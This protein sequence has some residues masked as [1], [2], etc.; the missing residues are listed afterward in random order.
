VSEADADPERWPTV[1]VET[2]VVSYLA[3]RPSGDLVTRG[4]Q[5]A[6][7]RW[8]A[9]RARWNLIVSS[10][11]LR[12]ALRGNHEYAMKRVDLLEGIPAV[13]VN[14]A[15]KALS[16][17]LLQRV[18]LPAKA[19]LDAEHIAIAAVSGLAYLVTWN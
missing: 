12:E 3:A 16:R 14:P 11:V 17:E 7:R 6:T 19:R 8:W 4:H 15:A 1:Y 5:Q 2:S 13:S 9:N 18:P 10:V